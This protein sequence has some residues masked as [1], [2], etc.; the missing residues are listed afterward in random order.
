MYFW[1]EE[2]NKTNSLKKNK[3]NFLVDEELVGILDQ[4]VSLGLTRPTSSYSK[5]QKQTDLGRIIVRKTG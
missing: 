3:K 5:W 4:R 2:K 1:S